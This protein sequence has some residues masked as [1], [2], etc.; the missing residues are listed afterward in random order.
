MAM[1]FNA[2]HCIRLYRGVIIPDRLIISSS[3]ILRTIN[4][5]N[6]DMSNLRKI[7][8]DFALLFPRRGVLSKLLRHILRD[9]S[10]ILINLSP[11]YCHITRLRSELQ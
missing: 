9:F 11:V 5:I 4:F 3:G 8:G 7:F 6:D 10:Y 2:L 1:A